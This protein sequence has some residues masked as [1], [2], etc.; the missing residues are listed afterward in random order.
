MVG[1]RVIASLAEIQSV[2]DSAQSFT[3]EV[4]VFAATASVNRRGI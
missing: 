1:W 2:I 3:V 4:D